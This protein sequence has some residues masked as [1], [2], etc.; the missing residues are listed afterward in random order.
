[1]NTNKPFSFEFDGELIVRDGDWL[2]CREKNVQVLTQNLLEA[3]RAKRPLHERTVVGMQIKGMEFCYYWRDEKFAHIGCLKVRHNEFNQ[4]YVQLIK[5]LNQ[6]RD[7]NKSKQSGSS[8]Q[9]EEK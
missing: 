9:N 7:V 6:D 4:K 5:H 1:M 3:I 8:A 2:I